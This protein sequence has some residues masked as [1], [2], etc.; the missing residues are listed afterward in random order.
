LRARQVGPVLPQAWRRWELAWKPRPG[1]HLL[2]CRATD[3]RGVSQPPQ[4]LWNR[5]GYGANGVQEVEVVL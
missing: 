2:A 4:P 3:V 5:L 1:R